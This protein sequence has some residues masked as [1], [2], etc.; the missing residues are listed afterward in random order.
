MSNPRITFSAANSAEYTYD[1]PEGDVIVFACSKKQAIETLQA[2]GFRNIDPDRL[3]R[4]GKTLAEHLA[5]D[6]EK[7]AIS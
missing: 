3:K 2:N 4:T 5:S 7:E 1:R 6:P